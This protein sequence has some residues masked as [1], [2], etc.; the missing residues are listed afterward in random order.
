MIVL[1][2]RARA[3][4][5]IVA[6]QVVWTIKKFMGGTEHTLRTKVG[7]AVRG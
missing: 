5:A 1:Q 6:P 7:R 2:Q 4:R 3:V